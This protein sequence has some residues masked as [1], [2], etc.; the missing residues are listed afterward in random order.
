[1]HCAECSREK[2]AAERGW[3]T[4]LSPSGALR[5]H[6]CPECVSDLVRRASAVDE[7]DAR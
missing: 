7:A 3:M 4:V 2:E 6:Y 1:M 5:I